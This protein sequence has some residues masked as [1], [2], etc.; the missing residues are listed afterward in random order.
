MAK[1]E[2]DSVYTLTNGLNNCLQGLLALEKTLVMFPNR[3]DDSAK[4]P[5]E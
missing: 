1:M 5:L 4:A 3:D 2:T